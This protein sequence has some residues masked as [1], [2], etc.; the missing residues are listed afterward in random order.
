MANSSINFRAQSVNDAASSINLVSEPPSDTR[1]TI[2]LGFFVLVIGFGG[3]LVWAALAPLDEGVP[4]PAYVTIDT[5][6]K[7]IQHMT[8]GIIERVAVREGQRVKAGD[9]LIE[10]NDDVTKANFESIRQNYMAQRAEESRLMA[11][12]EGLSFVSFH[13]DLIAASVDPIISQHIVAQTRLF[14]VR[15]QAINGELAAIDELIAAQD[16]VLVGVRLQ[17][18]SRTVQ[19]QRQ[20]EQLKNISDLAEAG[21]VPRNQALQLEQG[22]AEIRAVLADLNASRLRTERVISELKIRRAQ[23]IIEGSR[24]TS[25]KLAEIRRDTQAG[26]EKLNAIGAE[27][28]RVKIKAPVDGQVVGLSVASLG[29]VVVPG[30]KLLD[31]VPLDESI[32]LE[33]RIPIHLIDRVK[34]GDPVTV[35]FSAF[36]HSPQLVVDAVINSISGDTLSEITPGGNISYYLARVSLTASGI[37]KL[38]NK[39]LQPGMSAEVLIKTGERS[40]LT[41]LVHPLTKRIAASMKEE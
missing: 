4:A 14:E 2:R 39:H 32:V 7:A 33:V 13:R 18:E 6:R 17:I 3:F 37:K 40:M 27:L 8:G 34:A 15:R 26:R 10:L 16:A 21:Y 28:S 36:S 9:I 5:K 29:G 23:R 25:A 12:V 35:R 30:Q 22:Q 31:I 20:S 38:G 19:A 1:R 24:E 11:E 41:Y